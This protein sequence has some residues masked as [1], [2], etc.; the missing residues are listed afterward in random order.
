MSLGAYM[1]NLYANTLI[2]IRTYTCIY[3]H[4]MSVDVIL[5]DVDF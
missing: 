3:K 5:S 4:I 1:S 2:F